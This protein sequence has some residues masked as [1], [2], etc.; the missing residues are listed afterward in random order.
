MLNYKRSELARQRP[1]MR[2][3]MERAF[4][5]KKNRIFKSPGTEQNMGILNKLKEVPNGYRLK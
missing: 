4:L 5:D 2:T 1:A 3:R